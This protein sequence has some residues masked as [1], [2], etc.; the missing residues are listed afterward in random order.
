MKPEHLKFERIHKCCDECSIGVFRL[1]VKNID[2]FIGICSPEFTVNNLIWRISLGR[3]DKSK[4]SGSQS[5]QSL[6]LKLCNIA[7]EEEREWSC[8]T[9]I[10][11]KLESKLESAYHQMYSQW[12][13]EFNQYT[14]IHGLTLLKWNDLTDPDN[15]YLENGSFS[16]QVKIKVFDVKGAKTKPELKR[17]ICNNLEFECSI[18]FESLLDRSVSSISCGHVFCHACCS[19]LK[20]CPT[21]NQ[22]LQ[23]FKSGKMYHKVYLPLQS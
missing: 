23:A 21:C 4:I 5:N 3:C 11:S 8:Q 15:K 12:D 13:R 22:K 14:H 16:L 9:T 7:T 19:L 17:P 6:R 20:V 18:C 1:T 10:E 2:N